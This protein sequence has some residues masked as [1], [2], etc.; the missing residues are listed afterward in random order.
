MYKKAWCTCKLVVLRNRPIAFL[1]S[2]LPSPSSLLKLPNNTRSRLGWIICALS[3]CLC[4]QECRMGQFMPLRD[5]GWK[6]KEGRDISPLSYYILSGYIL[7]SGQQNPGFIS[8]SKQSGILRHINSLSE[9]RWTW[10]LHSQIVHM[11]LKGFS[12]LIS[13]I[14]CHCWPSSR[15][16]QSVDY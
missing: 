3:R 13:L 8:V 6:G 12:P 14:F 4:S 9:Q 1:A 2:S 7:H 15:S 11:P 5:E 10:Y 16:P